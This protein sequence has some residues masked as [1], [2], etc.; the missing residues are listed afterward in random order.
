MRTRRSHLLAAAT[1]AAAL[2]LSVVVPA[3]SASADDP[4]RYAEYYS[5]FTRGQAQ[6]P[7]LDT[8]YV[9]QGLA[10][11]PEQDAMAVS[12]YDDDGGNSVLVLLDR[13]TSTP[14]KTLTL[15]DTGHV[16]GLA[17]SQDHLWVAS[18]DGD[19]TRLIRYSKA[20]IAEAADGADLV[21]DA[22]FDVPVSSFVEVADDQLYVGLF[23]RDADGVVHSYTLDAAGNPIDTGAPFTIPTGVQGM[24]V[25]PGGAILSRSFSRDADSELVIGPLAGAP[26]R[27][28]VAPNM[29][30]DTA[31]AGDELYVLYESGAKKFADADYRVRTIHHGP[32][33][34]LTG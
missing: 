14:I 19:A 15:D 23:D 2:A 1:A 3:A 27:A 25:T 4:P 28:I 31:I 7:L 13:V 33:S 11:L 26:S 20:S 6:I 29:A 10:Y 16:G 17:T 9:P 30:E 18:T 32:L 12:Y 21:R 24:T 34:A 8:S 5:I 22:D